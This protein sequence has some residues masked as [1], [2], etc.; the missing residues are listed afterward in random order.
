[1]NLEY[2]LKTIAPLM[3]KRVELVGLS[4]EDLN[5]GSG[6]VGGSCGQ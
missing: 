6:R 1:M 2:E 5:G 3:G 4:A